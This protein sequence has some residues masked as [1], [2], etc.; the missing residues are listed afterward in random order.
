[1]RRASNH[2]SPII[3]TSW[4]FLLLAM[5]FCACNSKEEGCLDIRAKNF[6][7]SADKPCDDCCTYPSLVLS[8]SHTWEDSIAFR[9]NSVFQ[10]P[11][12]DTFKVLRLEYFV[13]GFQLIDVNEKLNLVD[14]R[15]LVY[16]NIGGNLEE[17]EL[18]DDVVKVD[19]GKFSYI[20][21]TIQSDDFFT[22]GSMTLGLT[23]EWNSVVAD[24]ID[25]GNL[26]T[27][28]TLYREDSDDFAL[29]RLIVQKDT[30]NTTIDT[31]YFENQMATFDMN[32][33]RQFYTGVNDTLAFRIDYAKWFENVDFKNQSLEQ[34]TQE[35][36]LSIP[37]SFSF[38]Q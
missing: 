25:S 8:V 4:L 36:A 12:S 30:S 17:M 26:S 19:L 1:M 23:D 16:T 2:H 15:E 35:M 28:G 32:I 11:A 18:V 21:G 7:F 9:N 22:T 27:S 5:I 24:S 37:M 38:I 14:E 34:V 3:Q 13:S 31:L 6:D 20:I 33:Q 29:G 10:T